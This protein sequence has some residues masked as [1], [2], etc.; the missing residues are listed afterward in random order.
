MMST[1]AVDKNGKLIKSDILTSG[2]IRQEI[3]NVYEISIPTA[4][5]KLCFDYWFINICDQWDIEL[6]KHQNL[7]FNEQIVKYIDGPSFRNIYGCHSVS[8]GQFEWRL[9]LKK[10]GDK[11]IYVGIIHDDKLNDYLESGHYVGDGYGAAWH[12]KSGCLFDSSVRFPKLSD[13]FKGIIENVYMK[14]KIDL[15]ER[16][17]YYSIDG[18]EYKK[19]PYTLDKNKSVRLVVTF[20]KRRRRKYDKDDEVELL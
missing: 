8:S 5:A 16:S 13:E 19:A 6:C 17:V 3:E 2:Y 7:Q 14:I 10:I 15:D 9:N 20:N 4:I 12:S 1:V 11:G 18:D